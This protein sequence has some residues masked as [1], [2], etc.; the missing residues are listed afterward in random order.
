MQHKIRKFFQGDLW[1]FRLS[2]KK[3]WPRFGFKWLRVFYLSIRGF[4]QDHC[5]L[6]A[7]SLTYYTL[8]SLV[9]IL[10]MSFAVARGFGYQEHLRRELLS[11]FRDQQLVLNE[12]FSFTEKTLEHVRGGLIA[13]V[14]FLILFWSVMQLLS[15]MEGA[16]NQIWG[17]KKLRSWRRIGIDYLALMLIGPFLFVLS[18]SF[19]VFLVDQLEKAIRILPLEGWSMSLLLFFIHLIPYGL[20]WL[21]FT[22]IY[23]FMPNAKVKPSAAWF[24]GLVAGTLYVVLQWG[25]IHFQIGVSRYGAIYGSFAALPLFLIWLQVSWFVLLFG[26]E[27]SYA[28]QSLEKYEFEGPIAQASHSFKRLL[29]LWIV[30]LSVKRFLAHET[31]LNR[32]LLIQHYQIPALLANPILDDL[33]A[34]RVL[35]ETKEGVIPA[36]RAD[37]LRISDVTEA[38]EDLGTSDFPFI[39]TK[40]L[41]PFERA[42]DQFR[43]Q[44]ESSPS[45]RVMSHVVSD[46]P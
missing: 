31:W 6:H 37:Q 25:Y 7:S 26:A 38:L 44:I 36:R 1:N 46:S 23:F 24:G 11:R 40:A 19:T 2:E 15:S 33:I 27:I 20:F 39:E 43:A 29:S 4:Y 13:G 3:G 10:A 30:H 17:V 8:M 9:P 21:L 22:F 45:N 18:S 12:L 42:L 14:G 28:L 32:S 34:A 35:V 41:A 5:T 16:L